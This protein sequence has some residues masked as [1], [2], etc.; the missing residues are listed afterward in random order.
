M[1]GATVALSLYLEGLNICLKGDCTFQKDSLFSLTSLCK[2][3]LWWDLSKAFE[4]SKRMVSTG[5]KLAGN[6]L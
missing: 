3:R 4:K 6:F 2:S 1:L 5:V